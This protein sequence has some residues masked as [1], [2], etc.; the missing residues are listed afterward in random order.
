MINTTVCRLMRVQASRCSCIRA[1]AHTRAHTAGWMMQS[2][3]ELLAGE[4]LH[5]QKGLLP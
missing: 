3:P 1:R 5:K 4:T 2:P